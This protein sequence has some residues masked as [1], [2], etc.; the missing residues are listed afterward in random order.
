MYEEY[1]EYANKVINGEIIACKY[2]K[3]ACKRYLSFFDKYDFREDKVEKVI[4]FISKLKH[5]RGSHARKPFLLE[6][7]Q[8]WIIYS[9]FGFYHK[10][11]DSRVTKYAYI[12]VARKNGKSALIAAI[13]L[14]CF[15][16]DGEEASEVDILANNAKQTRLMFDSCSIFSKG[17][18]PKGKYLRRYRD[19]IKFNAN[20]GVLQVLSAVADNL[21][22]FN[23][24]TFAIDEYHIQQDSRLFDIMTSSQGARSNPL[25][26]IITTAG[27]NLFGACY[28]YR[29]TC[30]D[31]LND[32]KENDS[33]F[34]AIYTLDEG[35][36]Y[37]NKECWIKAN[38]NLNVTVD[39]SHL[40]LQVLNAKTNNSL[41]A[42]VMT[43]HFNLWLSSENKWLDADILRSSSARLNKNDFKGC[44][45][46]VGVDLASVSDMTAVSYMIPKDDKFY[47]FT[48]YYLPQ[49]ALEGNPNSEKYKEWRRRGLL[50]ITSGN[51]CDYDYITS[52]M[53]KMSQTVMI[54]GVYYD[55]YNA[56]QWAINAVSQGL[57]LIEYSQ[58]L[59]NFNKPTK[60][61]E[62][63]IKSDKIII[64]DNEIT[65]WC[66]NNVDLKTDHNENVK[67]VKGGNKFEK[68][69][70]VIAMVEALGGYLDTPHYTNEITVI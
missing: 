40:E 29:S 42:S 47:Y 19:S 16:A 54:E 7:W 41:E 26:I 43:K 62:R 10:G 35:D 20:N 11:T 39:P 2:V 65:R 30:I 64:D 5:Y 52:D 46:Y 13:C 34:Q 37:R 66:F 68:I 58:S 45:C 8:K 44:R 22:G 63:L 14:Y 67:P 24:S 48:D 53:M 36:D 32:L 25:G 50:T 57:N 70:G 4:K 12:E 27:F 18:D 38:P 1:K 28:Q 55:S 60:E 69:D 33:Q 49:S 59:A 56:T 23:S 21:D 3:L 17:L 6:E 31:I 9:I 61:Y 15:M 51:V